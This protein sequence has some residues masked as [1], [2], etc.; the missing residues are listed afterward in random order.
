M[1]SQ[2]SFETIVRAIPAARS[3]TA[4]PIIPLDCLEKS[5]PFLLI[6]PAVSPIVMAFIMMVITVIKTR[7]A[8]IACSSLSLSIS[9]SSIRDAAIIPT[10]LAIERSASA[11]IF[12]WN[13]ERVSPTP[14]RTSLT[15]SPIP[16]KTS[17][18]LPGSL[19]K[20]D[21]DFTILNTATPSAPLRNML[22]ILNIV[23]KSP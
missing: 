6:E 1:P 19:K 16:L 4:R 9:V 18:N 13:A 3:A 2:S 14:S 11:L 8:A 22:N 20:S 7:I 15:D 17:R 10:D 5:M 12:C 21:I 23:S